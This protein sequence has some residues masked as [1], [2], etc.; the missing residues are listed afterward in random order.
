M[1]SFEDGQTL[2][3]EPWRA[4]AFPIVKDLVVDRSAFDRIIEEG[5]YVSVNT[6]PKPDANSL[7]VSKKKSDKA[8]DAGTCIQCGACVAACPNGSASLFVGAQVT[9]FAML[10]QG[11]PERDRRVLNMVHQMEDEGF[12][13]CSNI[14]ECQAACP[15]DIKLENIAR[16]RRE[17]LRAGWKRSGPDADEAD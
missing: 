13:N 8:F 7:K 9:R 6:G 3:V 10:P 12:G 2:V 15:K 14:G 1:R 4:D 16:M 11:Q 5:G 17:Y